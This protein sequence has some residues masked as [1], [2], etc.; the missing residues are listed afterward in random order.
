MKRTILSIL[1]LSSVVT[2]A[3]AKGN[4]KG[5]VVHK[6]DKTPVEFANVQLLDSKGNPMALGTQ[7][8][9]DG[10]FVIVDVPDGN[11][12]V[13]ISNL[14]SIPQ[15][16]EITVKNGDVAIGTINLAEDSKVLKEIVVTGVASQMKFE[17]DRKVFSVDANIASAGASASELLESIPSVEVDQDGEVSLRGNSSVT[18]WINGKESGLTADNRA[19]IL[20]QLP[21]ESIDR[22]EVITN[23]SAKY[24]PEGSAGIINIVLKK[25]ARG[26]YF[27]SAEIGANSQGGGNVNLNINYNTKRWE[28]YASVGF[29]M[30]HSKGGSSSRRT[31][32][33]PATGEDNGLF[34]NSDGDSRNHGNNIFLRAGATFHATDHDDIYANAFGMFGHRWGHSETDYLSNLP[35]QWVSNLNTTRQKNDMKGAH[36]ELG[37]THRWSDRHYI[38]IMAA[39]NH[40][41][42]LMNNYYV[43]HQKFN[44]ETPDYDLYQSQE[45]D[46]NNNGI[47]AK[48]DYTNNL[49]SWL[50]LEAG[51]NGNY[52][53]E[54]S[55]VTTYS[56]NEE[57]NMT[58]DPTLYNRFIY[59]NNITAFYFTLGGKFKSLNFQAGLR[60]EAWQVKA[61][62]KFYVGDEIV[63]DPYKK[64]SF[65]LFPS[66][67]LSWSLPY[68]NEV[69]VNY[70]RRIRRPWGGQLNPFQNISDPTN[71]TY[72]NQ[73]LQPE[74]TNAFELN[75]I[76]SFTDH[77]IS[78]SGYLRTTDDVMNRIS[79]LV[80][81][82]MYTTTANVSNRVNAGAEIVV[83]NG[84]F[85][86]I[87]NL[88]TTLNLYNNHISAWHINFLHDGMEIPLSGDKQN[89][90][91][92][93]ISCMA[94]VRL[95]WD[96]SFQATG[97]YNSRQLTAQG[98][99]EAGWNVDAGLRKSIGN[100]SFSLNCRDIFDSRKFHNIVNGVDY[101]QDNKRWRGGR[102]LQL[103]VKYSF[104]NMRAQR[105]K[106]NAQGEPMDGSGYG[107]MGDM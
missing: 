5:S 100:W 68:N 80:G 48:I 89:S 24:S 41:G 17:L 88:T 3:Y 79:Y 12:T 49:T 99:R 85:R 39:Y 42:G 90:F 84:F 19:S 23:P 104:G 45:N 75:Y 52:S 22:I 50:K 73:E 35:S 91:A 71:I 47:E 37:Y 93:D 33:D 54:N 44:D 92:W 61:N 77:I 7:T 9:L 69:Q 31:Y 81:D 83:K 101:V 55:P 63:T 59:T 107:E 103:T 72:G 105:N 40:W 26:G 29:R 95:P 74:Y 20:E 56:G 14:G 4:V 60:G 27:G 76:K 86:N 21:A 62:S 30:R 18:V 57:N 28:T 53:H 51:Y 32:I 87:L 43:Q 106:N 13:K 58:F 94:N 8:D 2:L 6:E 70:T 64:N 34:L 67:F 15:E 38:D 102:R 97:R 10:N 78:F 66:A 36:A 25:D 96:I 11:Y 1:A 46:I 98:S 65:A 82:V 16:R